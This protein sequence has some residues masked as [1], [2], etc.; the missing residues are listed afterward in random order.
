MRMLI[1]LLLFSAQPS[2]SFHILIDPGHGGRD[3]GAQ[4]NQITEVKIIEPWT[5]ALKRELI[6]LGFQVSLTRNENTA[7]PSI[8]RKKM[9]QDSQYDLIISLHANYFFDSQVKGIE[10]FIKNPLNLEDQKLKL[11]S[12]EKTKSLTQ[13]IVE[14]LKN[15][16]QL[17]K[18]YEIAKKLEASW[19]GR[20]KQG[21]FDV[22]DLSH[23]PSVLIELG[24]LSN[25]MDLIQLQNPEFIT[26]Q[27]Q[28]FAKS[29]LS[30]FDLKT[31]VF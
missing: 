17:R 3:G 8:V 9:Y 14:D 10:Y 25:P 7:P 21:S 1:L 19:P 12:E 16:A 30:V 24:Y 28:G 11:A 4:V 6:K 26:K 20:I 23:A 15:Q 13:V 22:L 18:S 31:T 27:T 29:I 5:L 2:L